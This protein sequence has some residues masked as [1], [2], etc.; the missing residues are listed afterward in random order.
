MEKLA[1]T[2][3]GEICLSKDPGSSMK[4]WREIFNVS[5]VELARHL[6]ISSST[7]SDYESG[8]RKSPGIMTIARF[9]NALLEIDEIRG[10]KIAQQLEKDFLPKEDAFETHE[11]VS[12]IKA[13][14][15]LKRIDGV[16]VANERL[17]KNKQ[18]YGYT[19]IDSLKVILEVP[20][21]QYMQLYGKTPERALIFQQVQSGRSPMIAVRIGRFSTEMKPNI[22]VLHGSE[23]KAE[24]V[25]KIAIRIAEVEKIPLAV[26]NM[27]VARIIENLKKFE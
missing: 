2:I 10:T 26:S 19:L 18:I 21:H 14:E 27:P 8:R 9:V 3:A 25:D 17:L 23:L 11:F 7:L 15:F 22:V 5:Q 13:K 12:A 4:K 16:C 24:N 1:T 6:K 20:V